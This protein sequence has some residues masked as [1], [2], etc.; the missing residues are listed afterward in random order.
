MEILAAIKPK[1][2]LKG[3]VLSFIVNQECE[4]NFEAV[5]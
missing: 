3:G 1:I 2:R 5:V 4:W